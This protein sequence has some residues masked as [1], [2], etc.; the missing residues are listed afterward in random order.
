MKQPGNFQYP[1]IF[2]I[3]D[4]SGQ[5]TGYGRISGIEKAKVVSKNSVFRFKLDI[6]LFTGN[7]L[8]D[9]GIFHQAE[10]GNSDEVNSKSARIR[11]IGCHRGFALP[12]VVIEINIPYGEG[13]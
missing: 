5:G 10:I 3:N 9:K 13:P 4:L 7:G 8:P 2:N 6:Q 1:G 12:F 11:I